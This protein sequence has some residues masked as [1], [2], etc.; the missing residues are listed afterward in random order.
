VDAELAAALGGDGATVHEGVPLAEHTTLRVGGSATV[1]VVVEDL[2]ALRRVASVVREE[3]LPLLVLGRGSNMLVDD[4]GWPGVVLRLGRGFRGVDIV[5]PQVR[6]GAAEPLPTV[7]ARAA[8]AGLSGFAWG[9]AVPGTIGGAV[10]MNAGAH[11]RDMAANLIAAQVLDVRSGS[12]QRWDRAQLGLRYRGSDL[13]TDAIVIEVVLE[14]EPGDA[15]VELAAIESIRQWR[16]EHQPLNLPSCGSVFTNPDGTSAGAL[17]EAAGLKGRRV[18]GAEVST[19]H[20]NFIVTSPGAKA[21]DVAELIDLI[22]EEVLKDS[23]V[24]LRPEVVRPRPPGRDT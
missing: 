6:C 5:G 4:A 22:R 9:C 10:R 17:I 21:S 1:L 15:E 8:E 24:E 2:E 16:R 7:A 11:G 18:G 23:G 12:L 3:G 20:A 13:P 14:L 19:L